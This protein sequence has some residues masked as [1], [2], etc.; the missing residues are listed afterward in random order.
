MTQTHSASRSI[1]RAAAVVL[2]LLLAALPC[3]APAQDG[4]GLA[5]AAALEQAFVKVIA[6]AEPSVVSILRYRPQRSRELDAFDPF[7]GR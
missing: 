4:D 5:A 2:I 7:R 3:S 1:G 6:D